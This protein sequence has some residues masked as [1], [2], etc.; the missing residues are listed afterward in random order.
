MATASIGTSG[1]P[2]LDFSRATLLAFDLQ[3]EARSIVRDMAR[4]I[5]FA[6]VR[7][8]GRF[9]QLTGA[10]ETADYE[11]IILC[12]DDHIS[13]VCH[14]MRQIRHGEIG[15]NPFA[16][17]ILTSVK[18]NESEAGQMVHCGT[19]T[20]I[21]KPFSADGLYQRVATLAHARKPFV[22][23][24]HYV[25][26]DRRDGERQAGDIP[27]IEVPNTL[28]GSVNKS[29]EDMQAAI[30]EARQAVVT[31]QAGR[32]M[33]EMKSIIDGLVTDAGSGELTAE[34]CTA[35]AAAL[36]ESL[37]AVSGQVQ[38]G[39]YR[40]LEPLLAPAAQVASMLVQASENPAAAK[41]L[42]GRLGSL[43]PAPAEA[44]KSA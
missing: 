22:A 16:V 38:S 14:L 41:A 37:E 43:V 7:T 12:A 32:L 21:F 40:H 33:V 30:A 24:P 25:G 20:V 11:L 31:Q 23:T 18:L 35:A 2:R 6:N 29:S 8:V 1:S 26:P 10:L 5:G 19:D 42:I 4:R 9:D 13:E 39:N 44:G 28:A 15:R 17:T 36:K 34:R 3:A 27:L